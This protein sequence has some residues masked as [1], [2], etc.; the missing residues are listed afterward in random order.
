MLALLVWERGGERRALWAGLLIGI[1]G[2]VKIVPLA[3]VLPLI[4]CARSRREAASLAGAAGAVMVVALAPWLAHDLGGTLDSLKNRGFP[5]LGGI[6]LIL[7]P[8]LTDAALRGTVPENTGLTEWLNLHGWLVPLA[9]LSLVA[10]LLWRRRPDPVDGAL[11]VWLTLMALGVNFAL[12]Y[13]VWGLPFLIAAGRLRAALALQLAAAAGGV[14]LLHGALGERG[15]RGG[16]LG[17][18]GRG[19]GVAGGAAGGRGAGTVAAGMRGRR[20]AR[21]RVGARRLRAPRV[22]GRSGGR[23]GHATW[24]V[25]TAIY[26]GEKAHSPGGGEWAVS[27]AIYAG[28]KAHSA[29]RAQRTRHT[30]AQPN[31]RGGSVTPVSRPAMS[32]RPW[33]SEST[34][35]APRR[36]ARPAPPRRAVSRPPNSASASARRA[37]RSPASTNPPRS[38]SRARCRPAPASPSRRAPAPRRAPPTRS[39]YDSASCSPS[40]RKWAWRPPLTAARML[41]TW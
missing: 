23:A 25:S 18:D 15:R 13:A 21:R 5:G 31:R 28:E 40:V 7:N 6:S 3:M 10:V 20:V 8:G 22:C 36:R 41:S 34:N 32:A 17:V 38:T 35:R 29:G 16:L 12:Q 9:A 14:G 33:Q 19:V 30:V 1:G 2:A 4:V 39:R 37:P 26:A 24:A 27:T 11:L